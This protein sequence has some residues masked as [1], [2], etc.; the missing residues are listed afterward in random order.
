M[1]TVEEFIYLGGVM[2]CNGKSSEDIETRRAGATTAFDMFR[3]R[4]WGRREI[5][6]R[7]KMK[8]LNADVL[9]VCSKVHLH[10]C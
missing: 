8:I 6:L 5:T 1:K 3:R 10:W 2:A 4:L 9:P 7:V